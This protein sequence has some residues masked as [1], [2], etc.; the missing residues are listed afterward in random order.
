MF[1]KEKRL[2]SLPFYAVLTWIVLLWEKLIVSL[3]PFILVTLSFCSLILYDIHVFLGNFGIYFLLVTWAGLS[4]WSLVMGLK[5]FTWPSYAHVLKRL[6]QDS[7]LE[8]RPLFS[9]RDHLANPQTVVTQDLW[10]AH[11]KTLFNSIKNL[12]LP[13][14]K[15]LLAKEDPYALRIAIIVL[16]LVGIL[17]TGDNWHY[18][19][20]S[21]FHSIAWNSLLP[22]PYKKTSIAIIPPEYTDLETQYFDNTSPPTDTVFIAEGS[23]LKVQVNGGWNTPALLLHD[24]KTPF[25]KLE[26]HS[27]FLEKMVPDTPHIKIQQGFYSLWD[28]KIHYIYDELPQIH[29]K[30]SPQT[31]SQGD[32]QIPLA[33]Y[34][35]YG[36]ED[37]I[38]HLKLDPLLGDGKTQE[39]DKEQT[40]NI[41]DFGQNITLER[42]VFSESGQLYHLN[43]LYNIAD[44]VWAGLP[45]LVS[46]SV[47]DKQGQTA[48]ADPVRLVL[49]ERHFHNPIA[50][51]IIAVRK[52]LI[53]QPNLRD[54][55]TQLALYTI[56]HKEDFPEDSTIA[57]LA[58]R[59]ALA[60]LQYNEKN[61]DPKIS[62]ALIK[63]LWQAALHIEDGN[64]ALVEQ[65]FLEAKKALEN[66][67]NDPNTADQ[68][69]ATLIENFEQA[70]AQYLNA[71][72]K[73]A[74]IQ[75]QD[76]KM[77]P[78]SEEILRSHFSQDNFSSF[79]DKLMSEALSGNRRQAQNLLSQLDQL[80]DML[81]PAM[82]MNLPPE[83]QAT[84]EAFQN[85]QSLIDEQETLLSD[86]K[87]EMQDF[88]KRTIEEEI[89][90]LGHPPT[91]DMLKQ[92]L[93]Q[94]NLHADIHA[95]MEKAKEFLQEA[96]K[97]LT[98]A[99]DNMQKSS[100]YLSENNPESSLLHQE[101]SLKHMREFMNA[102]SDKMMAQM[103][104]M[105]GMSLS[106][107]KRD[108]FGRRISGPT[109]PSPF[110]GS[111]VEIP[112][113]YTKEEWEEILRTLRKRSGEFDRPQHELLYFRNLL[114]QF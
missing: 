89:L 91:L 64:I 32:I 111:T 112:E 47:R 54:Q 11:K 6:E 97:D 66:A 8:H 22:E 57:Y 105:M 74:Q 55:K 45:V 65:S 56:L 40:I 78:I 106:Q 79:F 113:E 49:P 86:T 88:I 28:Q 82:S 69:L 76:G 19:I 50:Q 25:E 48:T 26:S 59:T 80:M 46:L 36:V 81:N 52:Q 3:W 34:D 18:K 102:L 31:S 53:W 20:T 1:G 75:Q 94:D 42:K 109:Q 93:K 63:L 96:S 39:D 33:V 71:L 108:P 68:E 38:F 43:P 10:E 72:Q 90:A 99:A 62:G 12:S 98:A 87:I 5:K 15:P 24:A 21:S 30:E 16:F 27:F 2:K 83:M 4:L 77:P 70:M 37:L 44:H 103:E 29:L 58:L 92:K 17:L 73:Q 13:R 84:N 85:L 7:S 67:L 35:D 114:K 41:V 110:S 104:Q 51:E 23:M 9:L 60:R 107:E 100:T 61:Q 95:L 14:Y 101:E